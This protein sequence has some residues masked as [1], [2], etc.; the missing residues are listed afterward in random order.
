MTMT[1][2]GAARGRRRKPAAWDTT[3]SEYFLK[4]DAIKGEQIQK[5]SLEFF[6]H[7]K[8]KLGK[9]FDDPEDKALFIRNVFTQTKGEEVPLSK[10][11]LASQIIEQLIPDVGDEVLLD[12]S[13][14]MDQQFTDL[15]EDPFASHVL[16]AL[17]L[18]MTCRIQAGQSPVQ[19]ALQNW[20]LG[21]SERLLARLGSLC[22][23]QYGSHVV[24]TCLECLSGC[25]APQLTRS[26]R[27][28]Q[29]R[30]KDQ[31]A[32]A[33]TLDKARSPPEFKDRFIEM[34]KALKNAADLPE[35]LSSPDQNFSAVIQVVLHILHTL[36]MTVL[37]RKFVKRLIKLRFGSSAPHDADALPSVFENESQLR[38]L[39]AALASCEEAEFGKLQRKYFLG[40]LSALLGDNVTAIAVQRMVEACPSGDLLEPVLDELEAGESPASW[41]TSSRLPT[42]LAQACVRLHSHQ[43]RLM[44]LAARVCDCESADRSSLLA[45]CLLYRCTWTE[46]ARI[47]HQ[48]TSVEISMDGSLLV[49]A[50]LKFSKPTKLISS[51][52]SLRADQLS[53][54][55]QSPAGSHV[56]DV[57]MTSPHMGDKGKSRLLES[58]KDQLVP[59]ACSKHGSRALDALWASGSPAH[60]SFIA[61]T[62]A[63]HQEQLR[64]DFF[65]RFAVRNFAL[66][67]FSKKR[68]DWTAYVKREANKRK[69]FADL[70]PSSTGG[71]KPPTA[72]AGTRP[73]RPGGGGAP[74]RPRHQP[75]AAGDSLLVIDRR[76]VQGVLD[77]LE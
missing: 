47:Q 16:Q 23:H 46:F 69:M 1:P 61:E 31:E 45:P 22:R 6:I 36:P 13:A 48:L 38:V 8:D 50:L 24:R 30:W 25:R 44:K 26:R 51:L 41:W 60:R 59:L 57:L 5:E 52:L 40:R 43:S 34:V 11:S 2:I 15:C 35:G 21:C 10:N 20:V 55:I 28:Q 14:A 63:P 12:F 39:E 67:L 65:G 75:P 53:A 18:S 37:S 58:L 33:V 71:G 32:A 56:I 29:Q 68:A 4:W 77:D 66:P 62:L 27:S 3:K 49:Q 64:Q 42:A 9:P 74:K 7:V 72:E 73:G 17:L 54:I 76:G 70:L 19:L